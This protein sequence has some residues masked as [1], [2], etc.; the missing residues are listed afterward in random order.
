MQRFAVHGS[1]MRALKG[2]SGKGTKMKK[3][4]KLLALA[5]TLVLMLSLTA[6]TGFGAG[7]AKAAKKMNACKSMRMDLDI[8]SVV[9]ISLMGEGSNLDVRIT[10]TADITRDPMAMK[11]VLDTSVMDEPIH[12]LS[13]CE[14]AA[15]GGTVYFSLDNGKTWA[16]RTL[17]LEDLKPEN[18]ERPSI[19]ELAKLAAD[20]KKTGV[21]TIKGADATVY[22]GTLRG[23]DLTRLAQSAGADGALQLAG[24]IPVT[25]ALDK[26]SGMISMIDLD[27]TELVRGLT[28]AVMEDDGASSSFFKPDIRVEK[29]TV[30]CLLYDYDAVEQIVIPDEA[31]SAPDLGNLTDLF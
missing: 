25:I 1:A 21:Q 2:R 10:G 28:A 24:D 4:K 27:M 29:C 13:Y 16:R 11:L 14:A 15:D 23:E 8:R 22:T 20:F 12:V 17:E 5:L 26:K 6:C 19:T 9:K 30:N 31:R 7:M 3:V 18:T